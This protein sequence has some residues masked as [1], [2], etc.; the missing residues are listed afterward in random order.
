MKLHLAA[1][2]SG[3][4]LLAAAAAPAAMAQAP[5]AAR[6]D[7]LTDPSLKRPE[8]LA[9]IGVKPGDRVVDVFAGIKQ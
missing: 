3:L 5:A 1:I 9:F 8:V 7:A 4:L 6:A 2:A